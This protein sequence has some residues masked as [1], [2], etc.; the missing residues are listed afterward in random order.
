MAEDSGRG[1]RRLVASPQPVRIVEQDAIQTLVEAGFLVVA[2]GGG[3]IPVVERPDGACRA[4]R[5]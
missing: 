3:G 5:P 4:S 2:A 1:W